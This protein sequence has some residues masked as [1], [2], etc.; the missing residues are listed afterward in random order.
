MGGI[1]RGNGAAANLSILW[2]KE[3]VGQEKI[4]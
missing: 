3:S 4:S 1:E 2:R